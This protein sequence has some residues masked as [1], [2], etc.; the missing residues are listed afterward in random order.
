M[1]LPA[2][3]LL[4]SVNDVESVDW[5]VRGEETVGRQRYQPAPVR[6]VLLSVASVDCLTACSDSLLLLQVQC[7]VERERERVSVFV[8]EI[9]SL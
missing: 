5:G 1:M 7:S 2:H 3:H 4:T 8:R 9:E 6:Q